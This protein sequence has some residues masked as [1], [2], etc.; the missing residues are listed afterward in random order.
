MKRSVLDTAGYISGN[1]KEIMQIISEKYPK[2][3]DAEDRY[4]V[5]RIL[6]R[7]MYNAKSL[8]ETI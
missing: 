7:I 2:D 1:A 5:L 8:K 3:L 6:S 4:E